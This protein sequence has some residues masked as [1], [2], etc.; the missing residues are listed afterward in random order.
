MRNV[1]PDNE[2][3]PTK[4]MFHGSK[5]F[6]FRT[7]FFVEI[8]QLAGYLLETSEAL[9]K[10]KHTVSKQFHFNLC[11]QFYRSF[12]FIFIKVKFILFIF[13]IHLDFH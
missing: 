1:I 10:L 3:F 4:F 8:F 12:V 11:Y 13:Y 6:Y 9:F 2:N 7:V 5:C